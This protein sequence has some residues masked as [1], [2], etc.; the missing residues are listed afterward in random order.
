MLMLGGTLPLMGVVQMT[1]IMEMLVSVIFCF[2]YIIMSAYYWF[3]FIPLPLIELGTSIYFLWSI[4]QRLTFS[5]FLAKVQLSC[6]SI[7]QALFFQAFHTSLVDDQHNGYQLGS[8]FLLMQFM[9]SFIVIYFMWSLVKR[10]GELISN[11]TLPV[12][13]R[14]E[15]VRDKTINSRR[16]Q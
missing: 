9:F 10:K 15:V 3:L 2:T 13:Q 12:V 11:F 6:L 4:F 14:V 8:V 16:R 1:I 7:L 5:T